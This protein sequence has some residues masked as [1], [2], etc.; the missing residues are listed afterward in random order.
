VVRTPYVPRPFIPILFCVQ[1]KKKYEGHLALIFYMLILLF[2]PR[3]RGL[4]PV[5][6][7]EPLSFV[8]LKGVISNSIVPYL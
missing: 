3:K 2:T 6:V 8:Y 1:V 5:L 7:S 4:S